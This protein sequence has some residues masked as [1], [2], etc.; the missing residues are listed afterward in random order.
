[1]ASGGRGNCRRNPGSL[2]A[3]VQPDDL[4]YHR[5]IQTATTLLYEQ[6]YGRFVIHQRAPLDGAT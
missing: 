6:R 1:M 2:Q 3:I 5:P 4:V